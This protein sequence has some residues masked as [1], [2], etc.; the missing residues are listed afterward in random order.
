MKNGKRLK[1]KERK[2]LQDLGIN[3]DN[4]LLVKKTTDVWLL[5][6][7]TSKKT[8]EVPAP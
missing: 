7:R 3:P 1:L 8:R 2:H 5:V 4:Y 6:S